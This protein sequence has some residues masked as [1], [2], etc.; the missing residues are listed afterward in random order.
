MGLYSSVLFHIIISVVNVKNGWGKGK[1]NWNI[2]VFSIHRNLKTQRS[3]WAVCYMLSLN[4]ALLILFVKFTLKHKNLNHAYISAISPRSYLNK[5]D[6]LSWK[7]QP[8]SKYCNS[9]ESV[10]LHNVASVMLV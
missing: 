7:K 8:V 10:H 2:K 4:E 9:N 1:S 3:K 5:L 6:V